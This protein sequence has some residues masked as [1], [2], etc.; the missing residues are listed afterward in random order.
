MFDTN[1]GGARPLVIAIALLIVLAG[2]VLVFGGPLVPT[3]GI[4]TVGAG[5]FLPP[6]RTAIVASVAIVLALVL[7][8]T[9]NLDHPAARFG[10][11]ALA[12][13]LALLASATIEQRI[14]GIEQLSRTRASIFASVPDGLAV[15]DTQ[16]TVQQFNEA[17]RELATGVDTGQRLH[18]GL[19]H[20]LA[21]GSPCPGGC[22]LDR[23]TVSGPTNGESVTRG[24]SVV[25]VEYAVA[26]I[27]DELSVVSLR[28][29]SAAKAAE[30]N[31]RMPLEAAVRQ[32]EQQELLR[33]LAPQVS[34]LP[35]VPGL[36]FDAYSAGRG[37][38]EW[39]MV[40]VTTLPD[41]RVFLM[42]VDALGEGVLPARDAWKVLYVARSSIEAGVRIED[43]VAR[44]DQTLAREADQPDVSLMLAIID[45]ATGR[46]DLVGAG[47]PPALLIRANGAS[48][49]LESTSPALGQQ[50]GAATVITRQLL[51]DDSLIL[52]TDGVVDGA[53][54]VIEGLATLRSSAA[55]LRK[56]EADGWAQLVTEAVRVPSAKAGSATLLLVRRDGE[57]G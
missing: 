36:L 22:A 25:P 2:G 16:G 27:D 54:D 47:H 17:L 44:T 53:Q 3:L 6:T 10:N 18:D 15:I 24:T 26:A 7:L 31:R 48:E 46:L 5:L 20:L 19:G 14:R 29:V 32:G 35:H 51:P 21:D 38:D 11:V 50:A 34:S 45:P 30:E 41:G 4:V 49:W 9:Q 39:D 55:A 42:I 56:R 13:V 33:A 52:Y 28:D 23:A 12:C 8:T 57:A 40:S 43:A 1:R 37:P